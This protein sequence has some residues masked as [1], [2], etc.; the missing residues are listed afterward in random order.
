MD[1]KPSKRQAFVDWL[2]T[3]QFWIAAVPVLYVAS[4]VP[5]WFLMAFLVERRMINEGGQV[6]FGVLYYPMTSV[7][8]TGQANVQEFVVVGGIVAAAWIAIIA[9]VAF[10]I[11]STRTRHSS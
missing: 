11:R 7:L 3:W 8:F 4:F 10:A 5:A 6:I 2:R 1:E 9:F